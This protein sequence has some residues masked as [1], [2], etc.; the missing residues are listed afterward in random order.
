MPT[1]AKATPE[2]GIMA[3]VIQDFQKAH[4]KKRDTARGGILTILSHQRDEITFYHPAQ[5]KCSIPR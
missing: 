4:R 2:T 5:E 1:K 3:P